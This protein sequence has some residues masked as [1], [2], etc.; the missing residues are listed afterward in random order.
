MEEN[1]QLEKVVTSSSCIPTG[2]TQLEYAGE[3]VWTYPIWLQILNISLTNNVQSHGLQKLYLALKM[4]HSQYIIIL[5][6]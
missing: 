1:R 5:Y 6:S 3:K 4:I 2:L